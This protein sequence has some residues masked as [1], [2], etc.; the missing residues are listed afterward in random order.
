MIGMSL[1]L[2]TI[3]RSMTND[4]ND[5]LD[6]ALSQLTPQIYDGLVNILKLRR[7]EENVPTLF[8]DDMLSREVRRLP[9]DQIKGS[10]EE[11]YPLVASDFKFV[12][13][14]TL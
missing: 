13:H 3:L 5:D 11:F 2:Y 14:Y 4:A 9:L 7:S 6:D 8:I 12:S 10:L 1:K